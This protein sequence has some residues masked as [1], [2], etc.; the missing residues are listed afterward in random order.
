MQRPL[1]DG[2]GRAVRELPLAAAWVR[3]AK[4]E[5]RDKLIALVKK[6]LD[7]YSH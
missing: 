3:G 5:N 4:D 6:N 7:R 2:S 1:V